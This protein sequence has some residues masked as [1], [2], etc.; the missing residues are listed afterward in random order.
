MDKLYM[1]VMNGAAEWEDMILFT[2]EQEAIAFSKKRPEGRVEI[3]IKSSSSSSQ[4]TIKGFA[5]SYAYIRNGLYYTG[6]ELV[7]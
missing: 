1:Y 4:A 2:E 6:A 7:E 3:F 5:P